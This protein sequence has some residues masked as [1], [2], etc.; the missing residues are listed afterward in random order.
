MP[1][2]NTQI[3]HV[4]NNFVLEMAAFVVARRRTV[5]EERS[6]YTGIHLK[7]EKHIVQTYQ[8]KPCYFS[9]AS[10]NKRR[11]G[12]LAPSTRSQAI[13]A[14]SKLQANLHFSTYC[15]FFISVYFMNEARHVSAK[16]TYPYGEDKWFDKSAK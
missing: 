15:G 3:K 14:L 16:Y 5:L 10:G 7:L 4:L 8:A 9:F 13:S 6:F 1:L 12:K 2:F 11:L